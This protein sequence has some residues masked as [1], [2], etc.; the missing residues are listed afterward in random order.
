MNPRR[1]GIGLPPGACSD[2]FLS[3]G[4]DNSLP[5]AEKNSY[6]LADE[7]MEPL[8]RR[9]RL[10][11]IDCAMIVQINCHDPDNSVMLD[12]MCA[13]GMADPPRMRNEENQ[14]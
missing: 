1:P 9:N 5:C 2:P 7:P 10:C 4:L 3:C 13:G 12:A 8:S 11:G 14:Q 6:I